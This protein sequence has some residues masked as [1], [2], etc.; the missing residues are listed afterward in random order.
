MLS[1]YCLQ[2]FFSP[3]VTIPVAPMVIVVVVVVH[4][5]N[6]CGDNATSGI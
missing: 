3:L 5:Y 6:W 4:N 2:I 1:W